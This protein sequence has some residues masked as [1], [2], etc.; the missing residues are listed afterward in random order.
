MWQSRR[1][2]DHPK[3]AKFHTTLIDPNP[4]SRKYRCRLTLPT[5]ENYD[6]TYVH[7][8]RWAAENFAGRDC[9]DH[10][11]KEPINYRLRDFLGFFFYSR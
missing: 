9:L 11:V 3:A 1:I 7:K 4:Q 10:I 6:K 5:F 2:E 8:L